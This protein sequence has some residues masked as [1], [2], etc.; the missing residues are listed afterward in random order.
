MLAYAS[1][2]L[3]LFGTHLENWSTLDLAFFRVYE[4]NYGLYD[5]NEVTH[6]QRAQ[7]CLGSQGS[8]HRMN[9]ALVPCGPLG[10]C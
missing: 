7:V 4:I 2:G 9:D 10:A 8:T 5:T 6:W 1:S 3:I